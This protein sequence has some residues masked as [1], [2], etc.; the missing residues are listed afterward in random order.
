MH[1]YAVGVRANV[2]VAARK[3]PTTP[4]PLLK[5]NSIFIFMKEAAADAAAAAIQVK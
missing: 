1:V 3:Q 2:F 4:R 5:L